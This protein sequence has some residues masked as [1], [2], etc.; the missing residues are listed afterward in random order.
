MPMAGG[1]RLGAS[2]K[3]GTLVYEGRGWR[4]AARAALDGDRRAHL[5]L[6][7]CWR[8]YFQDR[9][10][11]ALQGL[12]AETGSWVCAVWWFLSSPLVFDR[13]YTGTT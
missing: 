11:P 10:K 9:V 8:G 5:G 6:A 12:D 13:L 3:W 2:P 7:G 4:D 1:E